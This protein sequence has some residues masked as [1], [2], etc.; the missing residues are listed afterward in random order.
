[1][2]W[3]RVVLAL[4]AALLILIDTARCKAEQTQILISQ[5]IRTA[6]RFEKVDVKRFAIR[7]RL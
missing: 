4:L 3:P 1:M 6:E 2:Q 7:G 5:S